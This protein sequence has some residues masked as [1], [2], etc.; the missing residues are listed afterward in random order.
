MQLDVDYSHNFK[1]SEL[2][3]GV[4]ALRKLLLTTHNMSVTAPQEEVFASNTTTSAADKLFDTVVGHLQEIAITPEFQATRDQFLAQHVEI[5]EDTEENKLAYM[6]IF[7]SWTQLIESFLETNLAR[8]IPGFKMG[9][10][11]ATLPDRQDQI[12]TELF[13]MLVSLADFSTFKEEMLF[14]KQSQQNAG[15]AGLGGCFVVHSM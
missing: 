13:D 14:F 7:K 8:A 10:F 9:D 4:N 1:A 15:V 12:D 11:I 3:E 5:F 2:K 6:P